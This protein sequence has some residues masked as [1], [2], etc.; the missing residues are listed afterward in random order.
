PD[1]SKKFGQM[2]NLLFPGTSQDILYDGILDATK[3]GDNPMNICIQQPQAELK[4]ANID[5]A[6]DFETVSKDLSKYDCT[7]T[8]ES[9]LTVS[10]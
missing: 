7:I 1:L 8:K 2:V 9:S 3:S 4:F 10:D 5:A 6:N